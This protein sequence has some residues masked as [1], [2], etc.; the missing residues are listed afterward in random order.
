MQT[1]LSF[2]SGN[3]GEACIASI[4]E[5]ELSDIPQLHDPENEQDGAIYCK[6][7]RKFLSRLG[8][9]YIDLSMS[10]GH[11]PK[12]F[13]ESCWVIASGPSP[14]GTKE[15]HRHAVVWQNGKI[16]HDPHPDGGELDI[17][18]YGV[19]IEKNPVGHQPLNKGETKW[20]H[21]EDIYRQ[22]KK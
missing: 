7:L 6:N 21:Q 9:S 13:F 4:L 10:E 5:I 20:K 22:T 1:D 19:F 16:V 14:R 8:L 17:D 18:M 15:W 12:D 2:K 3:C 11:D